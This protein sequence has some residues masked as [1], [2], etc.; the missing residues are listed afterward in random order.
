[1]FFIILDWGNRE[2]RIKALTYFYM[3]TMFGSIFLFLGLFMIMLEH[4]TLNFITLRASLLN[5]RYSVGN[6]AVFLNFSLICFFFFIV[7]AIK[8]PMFPFYIWL[9][10]AHVE[11][12][13]VG[14]VI[15]AGILLKLGGY[16]FLRLFDL[17]CIG[18]FYLKPLI[19]TICFL[20]IL[21]SSWIAIRQ[22][23]LKK[24]IAYS[25]IAHMNFAV[26]GFV[27]Q[28]L[29]GILGGIIL[30][31]SHGIVSSALFLLIGVLYDRFHTRN[32]FLF[33]G[34]VQKMPLFSFFLFLF[35]ISNF[36]FP[37][38]SNFI[39][40]FLVLQGL[41]FSNPFTLPFI[42]FSLFFSLIFS[43][44]FLNR[45]LFGNLNIQ[46]FIAHSDM[47]RRETILLFFLSFFNFTIGFSP[48]AIIDS[49]IFGIVSR[50]VTTKSTFIYFDFEPIYDYPTIKNKHTPSQAL[51]LGISHMYPQLYRTDY[52]QNCFTLHNYSF[53]HNTSFAYKN[54]VSTYKGF[55]IWK[56]DWQPIYE[57]L[58]TVLTNKKFPNGFST[59][60]IG[61]DQQ[62]GN[63]NQIQIGGIISSDKFLYSAYSDYYHLKNEINKLTP[64]QRQLV[65]K[66]LFID[67]FSGVIYNS[68]IGHLNN[69]I[70]KTTAFETTKI[71][72][73]P[74]LKTELR[75]P[76]DFLNYYFGDLSYEEKKKIGRGLFFNNHNTFDNII[77]MT[78]MLDFM[79]GYDEFRSS[80]NDVLNEPISY[81]YIIEYSQLLL[82]LREKYN[83]RF[84][85]LHYNIEEFFITCFALNHWDELIAILKKHNYPVPFTKLEDFNDY[86]KTFPL[87]LKPDFLFSKYVERSTENI[88]KYL[89]M[90]FIKAPTIKM[91]DRHPDFAPAAH[92]LRYVHAESNLSDPIV[93]TFSKEKITT[94]YNGFLETPEI[95]NYAVAFKKLTNCSDAEV[96]R[97]IYP[98]V[99]SVFEQF[100][101]NAVDNFYK[102]HPEII[103]YRWLNPYMVDHLN[104]P[105][106]DNHVFDLYNLKKLDYK[107]PEIYKIFFAESQ[108]KD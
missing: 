3:Y 37:G 76:E 20:S 84:A 78:H 39:G 83:E 60:D 72:F 32:I 30:M 56:N 92:Y 105:N 50:L 16:G 104:H 61:L 18:L 68:F 35:I 89:P 77:I 17:F 65:L 88:N 98:I 22:K 91:L 40:E 8:I 19:F 9:P 100:Y 64:A 10:E 7:F 86:L 41:S 44:L 99:M 11:A 36:S 54:V 14:S 62:L 80:S 24:I 28:T 63:F 57:A 31:V 69:P 1:M 85:I 2:R 102:D 97:T 70:S 79:P 81:Q 45:I 38:T 53:I 93:N 96:A 106:P 29:W 71:F 51:S 13:T 46:S 101:K 34:L 59:Q 108:K 26:L 25:S 66:D 15:L 90:G 23:D 48:T 27:S 73:Y 6:E 47:S 94:L 58:F 95:K 67:I 52:Y 55:E 49:V 4:N 107:N 21:F 103:K 33:G 12:P 87:P 82:A 5:V 75:Q 43:L 42:A 74:D